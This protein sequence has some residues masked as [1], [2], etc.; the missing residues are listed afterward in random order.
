MTQPSLFEPTFDSLEDYTPTST[1]EDAMFNYTVE[2][3]M[4]MDHSDL[5][6]NGWPRTKPFYREFI[7]VKG[8][9]IVGADSKYGINNGWT[10]VDAVVR[11]LKGFLAN[12]NNEAQH[13]AAYTY[14]RIHQVSINNA[15]RYW[16]AQDRLQGLADVERKI[17]D[18]Q[19]TAL[20]GRILCSIDATEVK[21][22]RLF[23]NE[24]KNQL[25]VELSGDPAELPFK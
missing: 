4:A 2:P 22:G 17:A 20:K 3:Y 6:E 5:D 8:H 24:E 13:P 10:N 23:S 21:A 15:L 19:K 16:R 18:L 12:K 7:T 14:L 11:M 9:R 25:W 1:R